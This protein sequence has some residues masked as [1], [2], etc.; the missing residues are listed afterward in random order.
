[1][2]D[3]GYAFGWDDEI[4]H[5]SPSFILLKEG[6]YDFEVT[7]YERARHD[8]SAKLPPCNKAIVKIKVEG[9][10]AEGNKGVSIINHNLFLHSKTEGMLSQFFTAIGQREKGEKYTMNWNAVVGATGRAR[11]GIREWTTD[12]GEKRQS[13]EIKRFYEP[14]VKDVF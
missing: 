3:Q 5:D 10:D 14:T 4:Q 2:S 6:D 8:G 11:V 1:M 12:G 7:D 13:N 9:E